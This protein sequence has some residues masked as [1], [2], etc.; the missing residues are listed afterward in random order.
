MAR[1][2][3][4][5]S[6]LSLS[7]TLLHGLVGAVLLVHA[8]AEPRG[9][10]RAAHHVV[11]GHAREQ[12]M[13]ATGQVFGGPL[14]VLELDVRLLLAVAQSL[15]ELAEAESVGVDGRQRDEQEPVPE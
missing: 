13:T 15:Q 8:I 3:R 7:G 12:M 4:F 6:R 2:P 11:V 5:A 9:A 10:V 1:A 14:L